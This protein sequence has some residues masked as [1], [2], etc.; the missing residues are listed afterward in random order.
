MN[1]FLGSYVSLSPNSRTISISRALKAS[2]SE[3]PY[4]KSPKLPFTRHSWPGA[5]HRLNST[6]LKTGKARPVGLLQVN[7]Y[8]LFWIC[9]A[10][11]LRRKGRRYLSVL[12]WR[13]IFPI[14][15]VGFTRIPWE[16]F[17]WLQIYRTTH[18]HESLAEFTEMLAGVINNLFCDLFIH[19][20]LLL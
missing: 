18:W 11:S 1:A 5:R 7:Y 17:L 10:D 19:R 12:I 9:G 20:I 16:I 3:I 4:E 2:T 14:P 13:P 15:G 6:T 8:Y